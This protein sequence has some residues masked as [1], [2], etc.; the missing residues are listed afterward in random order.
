M[1]IRN[2]GIIVPNTT[3]KIWALFLIVLLSLLLSGCDQS[4]SEESS[5]NLEV[6]TP[7]IPLYLDMNQPTAVRVDDL[8]ARM[9][10]E[11]KIGQMT[12]IEKNS[13][14]PG[15]IT[16]FYIGSIL[17]GGGGSP[18]ENSVAGWSEMITTFQEEALATRLGIPLIYGV[19]AVHGH[20]NLYGATIFPHQIG[21]GA[22]RNPDLVRQI[23]QATAKEMLA[24]GIPWN[25]APVIAVPQDIRWGRT[26]E[27]YAEDT[28]LVTELGLAYKAGL[29]MFPDN[30][31]PAPGQTLYTLATPK[32]YLGDGGTVYG[33]STESTYKL[34]Q[35]DMVLDEADMRRLFLP[36]YQAAVA[37][38]A[39][40]IMPSYSSWQGTK[41]HA[42][43]YLL[44]DVLK[45][46][47][48]F[49]GFVISDWAA[50]NQIDF[51]YTV[52]VATSINAG[53]DMN[54]VPFDHKV[55][56]NTMMR[57]IESGD[58]SME[59]IDDAVRRILTV[60]FALGLFDHPLP[61]PDL[62][63][64]VGADEHRELAR[65][66]VRE[67][68]VL[69]TNNNGVLPL[70]KDMPRIHVAGQGADDIG[71]QSGG[72]TI[73]W[74]G[75]TGDILPGTTILEGIQ[76]AV[77]PDTAVVYDPAGEFEGTA[78][79]AIV[80]VGEFPYAEGVGDK[81]D[82]SLPQR[83]IDLIQEV[84]AKS[85]QMVVIILSGR[86]LVITEQLP[87]ADAWI[88]AWLPGSEGQGIADV[89]FGDT[90]FTGKLPFTWPR[91]MDQ[92]PFNFESLPTEGCQAPLFPYGYGLDANDTGP[93]D[94]PDCG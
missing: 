81:A 5:S 9:T 13:I 32:H 33:S 4:E 16:E 64:L 26:Y 53:V 72:W 83:D 93:P 89:L 61:D 40:S 20:G 55:F 25:F 7:Q 92:L 28:A 78:D 10:L 11:E 19:D 38:G 71:I 60:K 8:V 73:T 48:G 30:Y 79:I 1:K 27:A 37:D 50:I 66:A 45:G 43:E 2:T 46:E 90:P 75:T 21:L 3:S 91:S 51:D 80:V 23:G 77:S 76:A 22:T 12:Q 84:G 54:M 63:Q 82:L 34:D 39:M 41:M 86:P 6:P 36:P 57:A 31:V 44:T 42:H 74:Q 58:I 24:T 56:I 65:Q 70:A 52:A 18:E 67:S 17:S 29:Q 15:D 47:L 87:L 69:L 59:R 49:P 85:E 68:L 62:A 35:G 94:L 88:A 14:Q